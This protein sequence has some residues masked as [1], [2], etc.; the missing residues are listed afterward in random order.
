MAVLVQ[1]RMAADCAEELLQIEIEQ[2]LESPFWLPFLLF[3]LFGRNSGGRVP[4]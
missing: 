1:S 4:C 3:L 2:P